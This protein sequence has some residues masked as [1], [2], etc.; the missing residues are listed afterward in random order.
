MTWINIL[1]F[2]QP[3]NI[4]NW[5]IK[6]A[7]DKSYERILRSLELNPGLRFTLNISGCLVLRWV[8]M[9]RTDII[10]RLKKLVAKGQIELTGTA[11]YHPILPLVPENEALS[12]IKENEAILSR[13]FGSKRPTGFFLPE[14]AYNERVGK[15]LKKT[16]YEWIVLDPIAAVSQAE[17]GRPYQDKASGLKVIFRNRAFSRAYPPDI[18]KGMKGHDRIIVTATDAE[19]YGMRHEDPTGEF[20]NIITRKEIKTMTVSNFFDQNGKDNYSI[21]KLAASSWETRPKDL[22]DKNPFP[23]WH[24]HGNKIQ[25]NLWQLAGLALAVADKNKKD[26]NY[27]WSR[28]HLV[29]G[30]SS[31]TFWWASARDFRREYGPIAWSPDDVERGA[32]DLVRAIR[33]LKNKKTSKDKMR[34]EEI[35]LEIRKELWT[36]HWDKYWKLV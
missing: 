7:N 34:A 16:G 22:K 33:S 8:D 35:L 1:H 28:W 10:E 14:L 11:A 32:N 36:K 13:Y 15:L 18:I 17:S 6:E 31:C 3:A 26:K 20:E 29:R 24:D 5:K 12:Q 23:L 25:R 21:V 19:L 30:L 4:E 27:H 2:Y 9:G